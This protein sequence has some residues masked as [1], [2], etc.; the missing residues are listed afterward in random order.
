MFFCSFDYSTGVYCR[1]LYLN[2]LLAGCCRKLT[3]MS[4]YFNQVYDD[5]RWWISRYQTLE[6]EVNLMIYVGIDI[7][8]LNH[9]ASALSSDGEILIEPF[10]FTNDTATTLFDTLLPR[11]TK[12]VFLIPSRLL[13]CVKT[14][15]AKRRRIK[16]T[17][18]SFAKLL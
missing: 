1:Y 12:C 7:A 16:S 10:K 3:L 4:T 6:R 15:F 2:C 11:I 9:F 8:K 14:T 18:S 5:N 17:L 13:L